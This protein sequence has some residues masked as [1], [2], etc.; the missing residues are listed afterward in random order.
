MKLLRIAVPA[1]FPLLL[2]VAAFAAQWAKPESP[3]IPAASGYI[4]IPNA[5]VMP[6][7]G[8]VYKA[9]YDATHGPDQPTQ[10]LP[11]LDMAGSEL[12]LFGAIGFPMRKVKFAI[13]FH[14]AALDGILDDAHYRAKYKVGN[15][16]LKALAQLKKAGVEMFVCGQ[17]LAALD[18]AP[19]AVVPEVKIALDALVVL[20]AYQNNGYALLS[21]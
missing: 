14:G 13:V 4:P 19:K 1:L 6:E 8:H 21:F 20:M 10:I 15:P 17:N 11:A 9:V 16:N 12:N 3:V 18:I 2:A 5:A 7:A